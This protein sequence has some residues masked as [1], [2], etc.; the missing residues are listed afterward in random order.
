MDLI[1]RKEV[2]QEAAA[3]TEAAASILSAEQPEL[4]VHKYLGASFQILSIEKM[5]TR[6]KA[7]AF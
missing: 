7:L 1:Y 2:S 3:N 4:L 6:Y 5:Q